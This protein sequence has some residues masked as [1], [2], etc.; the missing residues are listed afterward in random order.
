MSVRVLG[1][2]RRTPGTLTDRLRSSTPR[3]GRYTDRRQAVTRVE[4]CSTPRARE[5]SSVL[6]HSPINYYELLGVPLDATTAEIRAAYRAR[7]A[8]Y[9]P[10]RSEATHADAIAALLN[11][12]WAVLR[13]PTQRRLYDAATDTGHARAPRPARRETT[14]RASVPTAPA[15]C[16]SN[17]RILGRVKT[18]VTAEVMMLGGV[19]EEIRT[20][21]TCLELSPGG[22]AVALAYQLE[23]GSRLAATLDLPDGP[24]TTSARVVRCDALKR[25][26]R[27]KVAVMFDDLNEQNRLRMTEFV[28]MERARRFD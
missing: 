18:L 12:A 9:H 2:V 26:G 25:R 23:V 14:P 27:W 19:R 1:A 15:P 11:E 21:C 24:I 10:D 5:D 3:P 16:T 17:R 13:D 20:A 6:V 22:M 7:I 8:Q 28:R 4:P